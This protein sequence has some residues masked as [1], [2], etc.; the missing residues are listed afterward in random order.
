MRRSDVEKALLSIPSSIY[1]LHAS[2]CK[3]EVRS[4]K[5]QCMLKAAYNAFSCFLRWIHNTFLYLSSQ[6]LLAVHKSDII[7]V[8]I[9]RLLCLITISRAKAIGQQNLLLGEGLYVVV[10]NLQRVKLWLILAAFFGTMLAVFGSAIVGRAGG[11]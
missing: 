4:K 8:R 9:I 2:H 6:L 11:A 5:H 7:V 1:P 10:E 3:R